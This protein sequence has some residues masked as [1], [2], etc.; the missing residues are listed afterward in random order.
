MNNVAKNCD[1]SLFVDDVA[2]LIHD[3]NEQQLISRLN[4][5]LS[6]IYGW[7]IFNRVL[8]DALKFNLLDIGVNRI[9]RAQ[10]DSVVYGDFHHS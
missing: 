4:E 9:C 10:R 6:A 3:H 2:L 8:F 1:I 7:A 5:D